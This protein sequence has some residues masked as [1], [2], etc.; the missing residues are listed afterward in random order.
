ML[1]PKDYK[2][3]RLIAKQFVHGL[4]SGE[5]ER[6]ERWLAADRTIGDCMTGLWIRITKRSGISTLRDWILKRS[7]ERSSNSYLL[8]KRKTG[9]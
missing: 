3:S 5:E 6:L 4:S 9:N 2:I 7:G 8:L 1:E